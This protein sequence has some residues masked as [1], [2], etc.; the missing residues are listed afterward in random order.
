MTYQCFLQVIHPRTAAQEL[1]SCA[2]LLL[3]MFFSHSKSLRVHSELLKH[4]AAHRS[5]VV[6]HWPP[7]APSSWHS[8]SWFL[9]S[10]AQGVVNF[11]SNSWTIELYY[12][13]HQVVKPV[14][15]SS[16]APSFL[17]N[18]F[19]LCSFW[20][21]HTQVWDVYAK[22]VK[23][24]ANLRYPKTNKAFWMSLQGLEHP[25]SEGQNF[26]EFRPVASQS[27]TCQD[28]KLWSLDTDSMY[29]ALVTLVP[30]SKSGK[31]ETAT[32]LH[33]RALQKASHWIRLAENI[34]AT[35]VSSLVVSLAELH[36]PSSIQKNRAMARRL[37]IG[38]WMRM[39]RWCLSSCIFAELHLEL[40]IDL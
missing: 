8:K 5:D 32:W 30:F 33:G 12:E 18:A 23:H 10:P 35:F 4:W 36:E 14:L 7:T 38:W 26:I 25:I 16:A 31:I 20:I 21:D 19:H 11:S 17:S 9:Q 2:F 24:H 39:V 27:I 40:N 29:M 37:W 22:I 6:G 1:S 15:I 3:H 13:K 28:W 34:G